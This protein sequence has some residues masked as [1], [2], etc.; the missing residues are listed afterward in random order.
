VS[1][2]PGVAS[3]RRGAASGTWVRHSV[4]AAAAVFTHTEAV[5]RDDGPQEFGIESDVQQ[6]CVLQRC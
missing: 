6:C 5:L 1:P 4:A 3:P 2:R